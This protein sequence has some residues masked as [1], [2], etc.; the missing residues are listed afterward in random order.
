MRRLLEHAGLVVEPAAALGLAPITQDRD[1][2]AGRQMVTI[3]CD[4]NVDMDAY[5][6]WV[7]AASLGRVAAAQKCC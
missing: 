4:N 2:F 6:R 3:V 1:R 5:G 7:R